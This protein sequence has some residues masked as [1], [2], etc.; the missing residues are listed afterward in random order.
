ML[1]NLFSGRLRSLQKLRVRSIA[2]IACAAT[3]ACSGQPAYKPASEFDRAD[4]LFHACHYDEAEHLLQDFLSRAAA[5]DAAIARVY[6]AD[7]SWRRADLKGAT[8]LM[9]ASLQ[10]GELSAPSQISV[11]ESLGKLLALQSRYAESVAEYRT[12]LAMTAE[13]ARRE[14]VP[15]RLDSGSYPV[16]AA[17]LAETGNTADAVALVDFAMQMRLYSPVLRPLKAMLASASTSSESGRFVKVVFG[18]DLS[19]VPQSMHTNVM[20]IVKVAPRYP[21][22]AALNRIEGYVL[23]ELIVNADGSSSGMRVLESEPKEV[24]DRAALDAMSK[25]RFQPATRECR[26]VAQKGVQPLEFRLMRD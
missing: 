20:P 18:D 2:V 1:G 14:G 11:E 13:L 8:E 19:I 17:V 16:F 12:A 25:W 10:S 15:R 9:L 22:E 24:F 26:P 4:E 7:L 5:H 21:Y 3:A 23:V 6:L